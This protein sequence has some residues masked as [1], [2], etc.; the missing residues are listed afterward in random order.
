VVVTTVLSSYQKEAGLVEPGPGGRVTVAAAAEAYAAA[1]GADAAA[2]D[3]FS[4]SLA[5][6][7]AEADNMAVTN[8]AETRLRTDL[9][10][11]LDCLRA[12]REAWQ[13][14]LDQDWDPAVDGSALY[15]QT[16]HPSLSKPAKAAPAT[17]ATP[18][19]GAAQ[20]TPLTAAQ[21]RTWADNSASAWLQKALDLVE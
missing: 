6:A 15:W 2:Y 16:L 21:V 13:A 9:A 12:S 7:M 19:A 4:K 3:A 11:V 20:D 17:T 10:N 8:P 1:A 14:E 18:A 5:V